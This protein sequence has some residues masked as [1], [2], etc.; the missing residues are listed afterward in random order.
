MPKLAGHKTHGVE[1]THTSMAAS[2]RLVSLQESAA[3][4]G[5][6]W[7]ARALWTARGKGQS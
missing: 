6:R 4:V 1:V 7:L 2:G 3:L 5:A